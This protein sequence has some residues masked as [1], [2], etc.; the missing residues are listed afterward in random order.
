MKN[1]IYRSVISFLFVATGIAMVV[2]A[3]G[4]IV[5]VGLLL[6]MIGNNLGQSR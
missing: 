1:K 3:A 2:Y 5:T 6:A 4:A